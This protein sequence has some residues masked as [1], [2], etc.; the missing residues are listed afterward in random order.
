MGIFIYSLFSGVS[1]VL[2]I[3][4]VYVESSRR[5]CRVEGSGSMWCW[6]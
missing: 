1:S 2:G 5:F 6:V 3:L 4:D